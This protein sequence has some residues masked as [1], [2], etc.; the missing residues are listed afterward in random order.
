MYPRPSD[1]TVRASCDP[2]VRLP[3]RIARC[4]LGRVLPV[5]QGRRTRLP[6]C[7]DDRTAARFRRASPRRVPRRA[8]GLGARLSGSCARPGWHG[9]AIGVVNGAIPFT[10]IA[11]GEQH[12]DSGMA[13]VA[14]STVPIFNAVL[15]VAAAARAT[16]RKRL[17]GV[18][19]GL[20]GVGVW[21]GGQPPSA[22]GSC[23][24]GWRRAG[25]LLFYA[26]G[27]IFAQQRLAGEAGRRSRPR[28]CAAER[29]CCCRSPC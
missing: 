29:S 24:D 1:G 15:R 11:W 19:V 25:L 10:L 27:G 21:I 3:D 8:V 12:I 4:D 28:R 16:S 22:G 6:T 23:G 26:F 14:N 13:A 5:H 9:L 18:L 7:R 20:V 17:I 2:L